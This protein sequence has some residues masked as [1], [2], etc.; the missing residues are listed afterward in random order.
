MGVY[1]ACMLSLEGEMA[2]DR[3]RWKFYHHYPKATTWCYSNHLKSE[4][5]KEGSVW[6]P[7]EGEGASALASDLSPPRL[8]DLLC[9]F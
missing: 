9:L 4:E 6:L 8:R 3:Q 2:I 1:P 5:G 7:L